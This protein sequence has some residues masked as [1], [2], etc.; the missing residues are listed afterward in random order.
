MVENS[1]IPEK[2]KMSK[3]GKIILISIL[4]F[5]L[6]I[7]IIATILL[8]MLFN[9]KG[10]GLDLK[11]HEFK[12]LLIAPEGV[13][14]LPL[15]TI[16]DENDEAGHKALASTLYL[17]ANEKDKNAPYRLTF[18]SCPTTHTAF[19]MENKVDL[20]I[21]EIKNG[22]QYFR[23]DYR[24]KN[25]IPLLE[26]SLL[27]KETIKSI[28]ESLELVLSERHY[29]DT[30]MEKLKY[31]KVSNAMLDENNLPYADWSVIKTEM[32]KDVPIY[33]ADQEGTYEKCL[34]KINS[35]TIS[36]A[37]V[38][39]DAE[40]GYYEVDLVLDV[41]NPETTSVTQP[42]VAAGTG[43]KNTKFTKVTVKF[44]VWKSG[45]YRYFEFNERFESK[46]MNWVSASSEFFYKDQYS[47]NA[48]DC[49]IN[50]YKDAYEFMSA[51]GKI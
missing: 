29:Y 41:N 50:S 31:Q 27:G 22:N 18:G 48:D 38:S 2:K 20:D 45:Y 10:G 25:S 39:Y 5:I 17:I 51:L 16:P 43:D 15:Y 28:N 6:V 34:H 35:N 9:A 13:A 11:S 49:D 19:G 30:S 36:T 42:L 21:V 47:Y 1:A 37:K 3:K 7:V 23:I 44:Q 4:S 33:R 26:I 32:D 24:L 12:G 46:A 14:D 40:N 8:I